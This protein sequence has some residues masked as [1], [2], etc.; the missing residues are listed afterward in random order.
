MR[1][2]K[3]EGTHRFERVAIAAVL[4]LLPSC[5]GSPTAPGPGPAAELAFTS[6][7]LD[8]GSDLQAETTLRNVGTAAVGPITIAV[9]TLQIGGVSVPGASVEAS[10]DEVPTLNP[11]AGVS[12]TVSVVSDVALQPGSYSARLDAVVSGRSEASLGLGFLVEAPAVDVASIEILDAPTTVRQG[13]VLVLSAEARDESGSTMDGVQVA[14][15]VVPPDAGLVTAEGRF[16]AYEP[17]IARLTASAGS[18]EATATVDVSPRGLAQGSFTV[19][20]QGEQNLRFNSDLWVHGD[21]AYTGTWGD[22]QGQLGNTLNVWDISDPTAPQ[23]TADVRV[24]A[25]VVNDVKVRSDGKV[26][27][28]S[29]EFSLDQLNGIT[30][31]ALSADCNPNAISRFTTGLQSGIHNVWIEGDFV[32]VV[33]DGVGSGLRILDISDPQAPTVVAAFADPFSFLHDVYVRDGLAFLSHWDSGLII[34][35]VGNGIVG[36]SPSDPREVSR[37]RTSGGQTHNAWYW[38]ER[39]LVFVGEEDFNTPGIMHVVDVADLFAPV[40]VATFRIPADTPHNF[41]LDEEREILHMAWYTQGIISLDV[42]NTRASALV[43]ES[44]PAPVPGRR[45][46]MRASSTWPT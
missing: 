18:Q 15:T 44:L 24:D 7:T 13:D 16:V 5:G 42:S 35:D 6:S 9:G 3:G 2:V 45:S 39:G 33:T 17:G 8:L 23:L 31:L 41:W 29:H 30:L 43:R 11:G 19:S 28:I 46:C 34:L 25:R 20:G 14:W 36:G 40:E 32:Y 38:P 22:R 10:P 27:V 21:C 1:C 26:A 12:V 4:A 37:V